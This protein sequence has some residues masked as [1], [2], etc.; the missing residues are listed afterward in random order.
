M[1]SLS[2]SWALLNKSWMKRRSGLNY[3]S[4]QTFV[5]DSKLGPLQQ[6]ANELLKIIVAS[7]KKTKTKR[8][9]K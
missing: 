7:I 5:Q 3:S 6:E 1:Q 2:P 4:N 8:Q 9:S